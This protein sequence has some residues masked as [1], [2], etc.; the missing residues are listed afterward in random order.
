MSWLAKLGEKT[1]RT[2]IWVVLYTLLF[3][4]SSYYHFACGTGFIEHCNDSFLSYNQYILST[5]IL[6]IMVDLG[7][8]Q[9]KKQ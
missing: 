3:I 8:K 2:D 5:L 6:G 9:W 7:I 1:S 4:I